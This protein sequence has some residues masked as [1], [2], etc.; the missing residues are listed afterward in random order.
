MHTRQSPDIEVRAY[1]SCPAK[2]YKRE[3]GTTVLGRS[4]LE[5]CTIVGEVARVLIAGYPQTI[6]DSIFPPGAQLVAAAHDIGKVSPCFFEKL[7][8]ASAE[9]SI[10]P[11]AGIN[12]DLE[13]QW[14]GHAGVSQV[15]AAAMGAPRYIPDI[16]GMHHGFSPPVATC[17][18]SDTRFGGP[19]WQRERELLVAALEEHFGCHW[20]EI[21]TQ[22]QARAMAGLTSVADW[23]GSGRFFEDPNMP[24]QE[25]IE[26]AV[27]DAGY[28][29]PVYKK[30]LSFEQIFGFQA[31]AVQTRLVT[32]ISGPGLYILE[33]PMGLGKTEAALYGAYRML[34]SGLATGVYFALPTQLTSNSIYERFTRFLDAVLDNSCECRAL[35]LHAKA[36]LID[37]E[38]GEEGRPGGA[39]FSQPKR[40]LLAPFAVG[41]VDQAL[42]AAMNVKHGF[43]RAFGLVGKVVI[44]D[45]IHTYDA[46]TG[47]LLDALVKLLLGLHCTVV[48]LSATLNRVRRQQL[49]ES[50]LGSHAYPLVTAAPQ[51]CDGERQVSELSVDVDA[52][53]SVTLTHC[54]DNS[55]AVQEA[56]DRADSGQQ[57]LWIENTVLDAQE[58]YLDLAARANELGVEC[59]LLH[60]RFTVDDRR[61]IEDEWV[62]LFGKAGHRRRGERGRILVGT[63]VLEQSLDIDADFL[64]TR[65][66]PSDMLLQR[67]GRLWRHGETQRPESA[68]CEAWLLAPDL[69]EAIESPHASFGGTGYVYSPY[70][71]CRS[72]EVWEN[73]AVIVLPDDIR[74]VIEKTYAPRCEAGLMARWLYELDNGTRWKKGRLALQQLARVGLAGR[75]KTLPE[76]KAQT[77]YSESDGHELLLLRDLRPD[78]SGKVSRLVLLDGR[79]LVLPWQYSR[80]NKQEWKRLAITLMRQI[81]L[82]REKEAP[83]GL[84]RHGL[85]NYGFQHCFYLGSPDWPEDESLLRIALVNESGDLRALHGSLVSERYFLRYRDDLGY[86]A[87]LF[88]SI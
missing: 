35:L 86:Q 49:V 38:M 3:D 79:E 72:L 87:K 22:P 53:Q 56:L 74:S 14:G 41:T 62:G 63:Q 37:T 40:G 16:L 4:V 65:F 20:P 43:V 28:V 18:A 82:V 9:N 23:I 51:R 42:M 70:V 54:R 13:R 12:P 61:R 59:G 58:R 2:T 68:S 34:A 47:V 81:V 44:L 6:R 30:D 52:Q 7:R 64:V 76:S 57:V 15:T 10:K 78:P 85:E 60:S 36:W 29:P 50:S 46:Y 8:R 24:W 77:R 17:G 21:T 26:Q 5:H 19:V 80:L 33:A 83:T 75:G 31:H 55:L 27:R 32:A 1:V 71:L 84:P 11:I 69:L 39:W 25:R 48:I 67:L 88:E 45:E 66:A 73:L